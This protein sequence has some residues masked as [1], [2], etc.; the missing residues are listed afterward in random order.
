MVVCSSS[1]A[2]ALLLGVSSLA[3]MTSG[4]LS[5]ASAQVVLDPI[6]V[7]A[8]K[9]PEKTSESL[10]AVSSVR[11]EQIQQLMPSK[12]SD[13][14]FGIPGVTV[15]ERADDPGTA[16]NIRGLQ[17]FGRVAVVVDGAR[18]N[19]QRTG[20]NADGVFYL[21]PEMIG[22]VDVVRGPVANIYGSGAIGGV[23]SYTTK[24]VDDIL[25][26]GQRWGVLT[27]GEL[28]SNETQGFGSAFVATRANPKFEFMAGAVDR[29]KSNYKDA[30]GNEIQNSGSRDWSGIVKATIR[31]AEDHKVKLGYIHYDTSYITGQS[32]PPTLTASVYDTGVTNDT[33]TARYTYDRASDRL[34][35]FDGSIYWNRTS[36][37]QMKLEGALPGAPPAGGSGIGYV[38]ESRNFTINT[39][40]FDANNTSRFD[41]GP[42]RHAVTIGTDGFRD[43]VDTSGFGTVFTPSG[44]RTVSGG[45]VQLKSNYSN[46]LEV[47]GALRY[48]HYGLDGGGTTTDGDRVSP[49]I[50]VGIT[51]VPGI[52]PYVT[53]AEGY[54]APTVTETLVAGLHPVF[55]A[56][57]VFLPNPGLLPETGKNKEIGVNFRFDSII[58]PGDSFRAKVN[59]YRNDVD[60]YIELQALNFGEVGGG[61]VTC[62]NVSL[63]FGFPSPPDCEQYQNISNARLTG[64]EFESMYDAGVW[65]VGLAGSHVKGKNTETG[66]PLAKIQPDSLTTTLGTRLLDRKLTLAVRWQAVAAKKLEDIPLSGA[67]P[68]FPATGSFN[69]VNFYAG[70]EINPDM[71]AAFSIENLLNEEY[72][73]YLTA[74]PS[75]ATGQS[76]IGFPQPGITFKVSLKARFGDDFFKKGVATN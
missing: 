19:F 17:D 39:V 4:F 12:P 73:R 71:Q 31:P 13:L 49:K 11:Q 7:L 23:V 45:F 70:Y 53:Y 27:H 48:D 74:Y 20:H 8:T 57:F 47:I 26:P 69:L 52:T 58:R 76:P 35:N 75:P 10:A 21:D 64:F 61:G 25:R 33:A 38:G 40:G 28:G 36:T 68:V 30:D 37:G 50:T 51:P 63:V 32:N 44:E 34:F 15:Q 5:S 56:P 54:R 2:R 46:W 65:F 41:T 3:L 55:F 29:S 42:V 66:Q 9:T 43:K 59:A 22:G 6:T 67:N 72:S 1:R 62:T 16:V 18:Q 60:N 14:L 24:D